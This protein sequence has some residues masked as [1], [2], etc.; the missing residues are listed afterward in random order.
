[1]DKVSFYINNISTDLITAF[2]SSPNTPVIAT[3]FVSGNAL[4]QFWIEKDE[5]GFPVLCTYSALLTNN[6]LDLTD[7]NGNNPY[8]VQGSFFIKHPIHAP[9]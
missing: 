4:G 7:G 9:K 8:T 5:N 2:N 3:G 1:M 6:T